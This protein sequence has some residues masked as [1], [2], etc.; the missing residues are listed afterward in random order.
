MH[1]KSLYNSITLL[2]IFELFSLL[3]VSDTKITA[4]LLSIAIHDCWRVDLR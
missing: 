3:N 2:S 1:L 4:A